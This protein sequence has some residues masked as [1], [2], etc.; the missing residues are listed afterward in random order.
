MGLL[1]F[2]EKRRHGRVPGSVRAEFRVGQGGP[3]STFASNFSQG[4]LFVLSSDPP[5]EGHRVTVVIHP[6]GSP[7]MQLEGV[8]A[9]VSR[10]RAA[11]GFGIQLSEA[12]TARAAAD[13]V[14]QALLR[15]SPV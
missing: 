14:Y 6:A 11:P 9:W 3:V 4:G 8:V 10:F 1:S 7:P 12:D 2:L 15:A 13:A 5:G